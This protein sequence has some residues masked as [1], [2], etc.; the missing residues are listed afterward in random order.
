LNVFLHR[1]DFGADNAP[2]CLLRSKIFHEK[3]KICSILQKSVLSYKTVLLRKRFGT[4][5]KT[6]AKLNA[7]Q[8]FLRGRNERA[9]LAFQAVFAPMLYRLTIAGF[10]GKTEQVFRQN[11]I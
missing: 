5:N 4:A 9:G 10:S 8:L 11:E 6:A 1:V 2:P 7:V 3:E